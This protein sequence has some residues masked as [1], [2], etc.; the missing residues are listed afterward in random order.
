MAEQVKMSQLPL[1]TSLAS[2]DKVLVLKSGVSSLANVS[3]VTDNAFVGKTTSNLTEGTNLYYTNTR[4]R[5]KVLS[6]FQEGTNI[7]LSYNSTTE[8]FTIIGNNAVASVAGK[9][10]AV[11]L[12]TTDVTEGSNLYYTDARV[13]SKLVTSLEGGS[14][15]TLDYDSGLGVVTINSTG[16]VQ[17][18]NSQT[19]NVILNSDNISEGVSNKYYS[20]ILFGNSFLTRTTSHLAEGSNLYFTETRV[21]ATTLSGM[22]TPANVVI[23]STDTLPQAI[24]SLQGQISYQGSS[25][26]NHSSNTANPHNVTKTQVGLGN[27][28]NIDATNATNISSGTL[29]D[30]RLSAN[31]TAQGNTFNSANQ[32]VKLNGSGQ[33]PALDGSLLTNVVTQLTDLTDVGVSGLTS[34]QTLYYTGSVWTNITLKK[35]S[36]HE[37]NGGYSYCGKAPYGSSETS[38]VWTIRRIQILRDG[39]TVTTTATN[40]TW[41]GRLTHTYS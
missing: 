13:L 34:G 40:V 30:A 27:V 31:I 1:V 16:N 20:D 19:G 32:L 22:P 21:R 4:V 12:N 26:T 14:N 23:S 2:T 15:V 35:V 38:A 5:D 36:R 24:S 37:F 39:N 9:T 28:P 41:S 25:L 3:L 18:V 8:K 10:G 33:L 7:T 11:S 17:S 29:A 6:M